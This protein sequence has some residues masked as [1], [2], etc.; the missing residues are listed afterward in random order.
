MSEFD[1][2]AR[3]FTPAQHCAPGV[4]VGVGD[5]AAIVRIPDGVDWVTCVDTLVAGVHFPLDATPYSIGW[6]ALAVNLSDLAAMGATPAWVTMALTLPEPNEAWL[7]DFMQ[8]FNALAQRYHVD[9]IGGDTTRGPLSITLQAN[10]F[11]PRGKALLRRGAKP[12]DYLCVSGTLGD[13]GA[14]LALS[15]NK[16][17]CKEPDA[18]HYLTQ[19][20]HTPT[21]RVELGQNLR[22]IA[23]SAIDISDGLIG[24]IQHILRASAVGAIIDL[25]RLPVSSALTNSFDRAQAW[26]WAL[27]AGDD[28]ELCFTLPAQALPKLNIVTSALSIPCTIIGEITSSPGLVLRREGNAV[29]IQAFLSYDHFRTL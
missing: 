9:L 18:M 11:V 13:A 24:D 29:D 25:E 7:R 1:L 8:G 17:T 26:S 15:C 4:Q 27:S 12:G 21:P 20:L 6:K 28:Y 3:Y 22:A 16:I 5:D 23:T 14:G 2:I 19:R 10:G